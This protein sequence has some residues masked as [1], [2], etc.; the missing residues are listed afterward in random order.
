MRN[1]ILMMLRS[2][3]VLGISSPAWAVD[4]SDFT[5]LEGWMVV[6]V[7][8]V[9]GKFEGCDIGKRIKF[10]NGWTLICKTYSDTL[11][12]RPAAVIFSKKYRYNER[13]YWTIKALIDDEF[14]DME[15]IPESESVGK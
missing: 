7:T 9:S 10:E 5:G 4:A 15:L 1:V 8:Y 2:V 13:S 6:G 14:Y 12:D 3:L 11:S